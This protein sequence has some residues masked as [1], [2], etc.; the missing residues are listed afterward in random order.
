MGYKGKKR[1]IKWQKREKR[2]SVKKKIEKVKNTIEK[3]KINEKGNEDKC[4]ERKKE[5]S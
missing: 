4:R 1:N 2:E 3:S 5:S